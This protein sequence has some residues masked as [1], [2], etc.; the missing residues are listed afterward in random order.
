MCKK[1]GY[2]IG[3]AVAQKLLIGRKSLFKI[4]VALFNKLLC[5]EKK[6]KKFFY[7]INKNEFLI[8]KLKFFIKV[9]IFSSKFLLQIKPEILSFNLKNNFVTINCGLTIVDQR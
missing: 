2:F 3:T 1:I 7:F 9:P 6:I 4:K 5:Y 8:F